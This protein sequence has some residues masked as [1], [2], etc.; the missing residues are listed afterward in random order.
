MICT[1]CGADIPTNQPFCGACGFKVLP[2]TLDDLRLR[3]SALEQKR[4]DQQF[5]D[6]DTT[7]K[8]LNRLMSWAKLF[9]FFVG[10]PI[11]VILIGLTIFVGKSFKDLGDVA[12][13]ARKSIQ[14]IL[15]QARAGAENA[16][17]TAIDASR[18]SQEVNRAIDLTRVEL[19]A[20]D[21]QISFRSKDVEQLE[22]QLKRSQT[23]VL[24]LQAEVV[25]SA[26]EVNRL[27]Q[28]IEVV[29]TDKNAVS[30]QE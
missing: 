3:I 7:E 15:E 24:A 23:S 27:R 22:G 29:S 26:T 9:A 18:K 25:R 28:Q 12:A 6:V 16:K 10:I 13:D 17:R 8:V 1:N 21:K 11:G 5:L 19:S 14:P 20:L 4:T 30:I 2:E